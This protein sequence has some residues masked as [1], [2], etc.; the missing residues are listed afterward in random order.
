MKSLLET[1]TLNAKLFEYTK[2]SKYSDILFLFHSINLTP[3]LISHLNSKLE[4]N[5]MIRF[6]IGY[7]STV[8]DSNIFMIN[9][10]T[11]KNMKSKLF[12]CYMDIRSD[13]INLD[14]NYKNNTIVYNL[15]KK[16]FSEQKMNH[17]LNNSD[18]IKDLLKYN[19]I[20][21]EKYLFNSS[22]IDLK[23]IDEI[24]NDSFLN[25]S[26][27]ISSHV[28]Y[29]EKLY[30]LKRN[31]FKT[32]DEF[33]MCSKKENKFQDNEYRQLSQIFNDYREIECCE[34]VKM[35]LNSKIEIK[36]ILKKKIKFQEII[37]QTKSC[38]LISAKYKKKDA[39]GNIWIE[40]FENE[41]T[42]RQIINIH[43]TAKCII[44][45]FN[46][47]INSI[48]VEIID[49]FRINFSSNKMICIETNKN[50]K[51]SI[52]TYP[53][54]FASDV[55][56]CL[57]HYSFETFN[58]MITD[59]RPIEIEKSKKLL[60]TEPVIFS[61]EE[62]KYA[63]SNLGTKGIESFFQAHLCNTFCKHLNL[64]KKN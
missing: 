19:G 11:N 10:F 56:E 63:S 25:K 57:A 16:D 34:F 49:I 17:F 15:F 43:L 35:C 5:S 45:D 33:I 41:D 50:I 8:D 61:L 39:K 59:L 37:E 4:R 44:G 32:I 28:K 22:E 9:N 1:P 52:L 24:T 53:N 23:S 20:K 12:K 51:E 42:L 62:N 55:I 48:T 29:L 60:I 7:Y 2:K 27:T 14:W 58:L 54:E 21:F 36:N 64:K 46:L 18:Q 30:F 26:I 13:I 47:K 31:S 38:S 3:H 6:A 40:L